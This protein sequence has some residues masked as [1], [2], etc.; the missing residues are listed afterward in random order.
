MIKD[1]RLKKGETLLVFRRNVKEVPESAL[2]DGD[3]LSEGAKVVF[4]EIFSDYSHE[5]KMNKEDCT[6]FV[7]GCTGNP[8]SIDDANI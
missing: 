5:G 2:L 1:L 6:R 3:N 8:C 4:S 7:T